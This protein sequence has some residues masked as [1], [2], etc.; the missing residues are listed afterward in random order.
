[1][2]RLALPKGRNLAVAL[3]AL[4]RAGFDLRPH[5]DPR[6]L[7]WTLPDLGLEVLMLKDADVPRYVEHGVA[8]LGVVGSDVLAESEADLLVPVRWRDGRSRLSLLGLPGTL[9]AAGSAVRLATKYPRIAARVVAARAW[10]VEVVSL[11]GSVELAPLLGL[12]DLALDVVQTGRTLRDNGLAE[13]EVV[14]E[15]APCL[16]ASRAAWQRQR[17]ALNAL[18]ARL[19]ATEAVA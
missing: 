14:A 3:D 10:S 9:P 5:D 2:I 6:R 19:E 8:A 4:S 13:L 18:V 12:A 11:A 7:R 1:M 17:A 15:V 16:V